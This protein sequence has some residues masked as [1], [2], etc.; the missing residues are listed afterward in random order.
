MAHYL[1]ILRKW[2]ISLLNQLYF[3]FVLFFVL[4]MTLNV[5]YLIHAI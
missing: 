1:S 5:F 4:W 2:L 3:Y